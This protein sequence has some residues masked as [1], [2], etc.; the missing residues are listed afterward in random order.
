ML[1]VWPLKSGRADETSGNYVQLIS[2]R[3]WEHCINVLE[4]SMEKRQPI[5]WKLWVYHVSI[6]NYK[7]VSCEPTAIVYNWTLHQSNRATVEWRD[8]KI[9]CCSRS[10]CSSK[11][12]VIKHFNG[13]VFIVHYFPSFIPR[14]F[15]RWNATCL[16]IDIDTRVL[17]TQFI[18]INTYKN[19]SG[20]NR[21]GCHSI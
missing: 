15:T 6:F 7:A 9:Y 13:I 4:A 8:S 21:V 19:V 1:L 20:W 12:K 5:R 10:S 2:I 16:A 3:P 18:S 17:Y 11:Q 14:S